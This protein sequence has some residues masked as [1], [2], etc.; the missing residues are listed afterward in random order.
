[1]NQIENKEKR[2]N[3]KHS[4]FAAFLILL[5][6]IFFTEFKLRIN[7]HEYRSCKD[8]EES[9]PCFKDNF[10]LRKIRENRIVTARLSLSMGA[11]T[12]TIPV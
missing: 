5:F 9:D 7:C 8:K 6:A 1:M 10:S 4:R 2:Q 3:A 12:L 11:T